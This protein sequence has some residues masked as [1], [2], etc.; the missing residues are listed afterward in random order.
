MVLS[1]LEPSSLCAF[2]L[3]LEHAANLAIA[4]SKPN[5]KT[6][7]HHD[8]VNS[9]ISWGWPWKRHTMLLWGDVSGLP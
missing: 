7:D 9:E 8:P 3:L 5:K 1:L 6:S 4:V 2:S